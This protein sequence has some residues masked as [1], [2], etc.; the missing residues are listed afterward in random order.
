MA[1]NS[2]DYE[3]AVSFQAKVKCFIGKTR[4]IRALIKLSLR[5]SGRLN[6]GCEDTSVNRAISP[7]FIQL[8]VISSAFFIGP[9]SSFS[10]FLHCLLLFVLFFSLS[11]ILQSHMS[12]H[13]NSF[14]PLDN[15]VIKISFSLKCLCRVPKRYWS[16]CEL[17]HHIKCYQYNTY[18]NKSGHSISIATFKI[19]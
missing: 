15:T 7:L 16:S 1:V 10:L 13:S 8:T 3:K 4:T 11:P 12:I 5:R 6:V 17:P 14:V 9:S 18:R 19:S 2:R